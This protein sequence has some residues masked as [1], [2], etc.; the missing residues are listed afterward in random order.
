[1]TD[2]S[3]ELTWRDHAVVFALGIGLAVI[4][5]LSG[6]SSE[7]PPDLWGEI[8]VACGLRPPPTVFPC[9][10]RILAAQLF[11]YVGI[12]RGL[13]VLR[14]A[15]PVGLGVVAILVFGIF[16]ELLP[17]N[18]RVR[19]RRMGW[20]R[21]IVRFVLLQGVLFF[22]CS[23]P[24]WHAGQILSPTL[25]LLLLTLVAFRLFLHAMRT[26]SRKYAILM[27]A[28]SGLL[29]A[30]SVL[31]FVPMVVFPLVVILRS[32]KAAL[33]LAVPIMGNPLVRT[34][35]FRRM[36]LAFLAGFLF[37]MAFTTLFFNMHDGLVAHDWNAFTYYIHYL[38]RYAQ[39]VQEAATRVGWIFIVCIV[40]LPLTMA[41]MLFRYATDDDRFLIYLHA[42]FFGI[43]GLLAF[44]QSAGWRQFWFWTWIS[45][46]PSVKSG[47]LLCLCMLATSMLAMMALCVLG[48]EIYFRNYRRIAMI[49]YQDAVEDEPVAER[50]VRTFRLI[51]RL[52]R[53]VLV[54]EPL[55][56]V[57]FIVPLKFMSPE[58][59]MAAIVNEGVRCTAEECGDAPVLFTDGTLDAAVEVAAAMRNASSDSSDHT[60]AL[61]ALSM[62]P[63]STPCDI[64]LRVRGENDEE[65][66]TMLSVGAVETLRTWLRAKPEC[67]TNI[68]LQLGFDLW[69][70]DKLPVPPCAGFVARTAGFPPGVAEKG[71]AN[72]LAL[73]DRIMA[74][75]EKS[76]PMAVVNRDLRSK[77]MFTQWRIA[78]MCRIRADAAD[79]AGDMPLAMRESEL[80]DSLDAKN[81]AFG[82]IRK[83]M[84]WI[85]QQAGMRLTPREG[86]KIGL[87][88]ADFRLA[89]T[90]AQQVLVSDPEN[91]GA[92][93]AMGM[94]YFVE[95]QYG[96]AEIYLKRCLAKSPNEPAALNNLA[97]TQVHLG[98]LAEAETNATKALEVYPS[99]KEVKETYDHIRKLQGK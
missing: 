17:N 83:Q 93:F 45:D 71:R 22:V 75:Y 70:H 1:M 29:A 65:N 19:M 92:N 78:R 12:A 9:L 26:S 62:M 38:H 61:K 37:M 64:Y 21:R 46:G 25:L 15:G 49:R 77:F 2:D 40:V 89:R 23:D 4:A 41:A 32:R 67:A 48:V 96:R 6:N 39:T 11:D 66:R 7:V 58:P 57:A 99:S 8:S 52:V 94:A 59:E 74:L 51:D 13:V 63:G 35:T 88:R 50:I 91:S 69:R 84:N 20:S 85:V 43:F 55:V 5:W 82:K 53:A 24:V 80:A 33:E 54:Y 10:W 60:L 81:V 95:E 68:A 42:V 31:G 27:S 18:L 72:A 98:R 73:A 97:I 34:I 47:Y 3:G 14:A 90:F 28:V 87:D 30:E 56:A 36:S 76:D 44:L 86:L 16:D 79:K